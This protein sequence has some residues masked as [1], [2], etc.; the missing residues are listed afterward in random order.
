M[1]TVRKVIRKVLMCRPL[2]FTVEH[3]YNPWMKPGTVDTKKALEQWTGLKKSYE[4]LGISVKV[5]DQVKGLH[6]M[7]FA[8]D[9]GIVKGRE[10]LLSNFRPKQ[11]QG[12]RLQYK[13]WFHKNGYKIYSL[14]SHHYLEGNGETYFWNDIIFVG[15]GYRSDPEIPRVLEKMY[16][17]KV[18]YLKI[19]DPAFYHLDVGFFPLNNSTIF[20]YPPA[21]SPGTLKELKQRVPNLI[22]FS[23]KE[24][25]GFSANSVVTDHHVIVQKGNPTF[26]NKLH[27]L[28]YKTNEVD[29]SEFMKSGGGAHCLTNVLEEAV[30]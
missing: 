28:G 3:V 19:M 20:Y 15:T 30:N 23:K 11:R 17:R 22:P 21:Y 13:K 27:N 2:F 25:F 7:V 24:A 29:L 1:K 14:P 26:V 5:I 4:N 18:V 9:Q 10:V 16:H 8:T 6:D 12:E